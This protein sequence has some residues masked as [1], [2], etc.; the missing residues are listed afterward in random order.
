MNVLKS[1]LMSPCR[2]IKHSCIILGREKMQEKLK[3]M[4]ILFIIFIM[5]KTLLK[6]N[7]ATNRLFYC[8]SSDCSAKLAV[9][10]DIRFSYLF[11]LFKQLFQTRIPVDSNFNSPY[12]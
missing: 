12:S 5:L 1:F 2:L 11:L 10:N 8:S 6:V 9:L 4:N 3:A 7:V